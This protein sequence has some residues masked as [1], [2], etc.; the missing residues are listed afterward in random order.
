MSSLPVIGTN[1]T[2]YPRLSD[3][4]VFGVEENAMYAAVPRSDEKS[5]K[6]R[7]SKL[8][9]KENAIVATKILVVAIAIAGLIAASVFTFGLAGVAAGLVAKGALIGVSIGLSL[10][11]PAVAVVAYKTDMHR[12]TGNDCKDTLKF[13]G[14]SLLAA[15]TITGVSAGIGASVG[16][17]AGFNDVQKAAAIAIVLVV[18][19][20]FGAMILGRPQQR[21]LD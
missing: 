13:A 16:A 12:Y 4:P 11:V 1:S 18:G 8:F 15:A 2:I 9:T 10:S 14:G 17:F 3:S 19:F 6:N 7:L 5:I 20:F 21:G